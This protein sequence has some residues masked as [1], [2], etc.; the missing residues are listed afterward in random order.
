MLLAVRDAFKGFVEALRNRGCGL[1][2][3]D[4]SLAMTTSALASAVLLEAAKSVSLLNCVCE[5]V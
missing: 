5:S 3:K 4:K 2:G 1:C